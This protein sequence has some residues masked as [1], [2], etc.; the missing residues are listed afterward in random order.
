MDAVLKPFVPKAR[1][2]PKHKKTE[3][4]LQ[5][6]V[7]RYICKEYPDKGIVYSDYAAGVNLTDHQRRE[8]MAQRSEDGMPDIYIDYPSRG[9]HG[10]RI[11][12]KAEGTHIYK[13]DGKTLRKTPYTRRYIRNGKL[14]IK[15]GDHL[16]EQ[17]AV[18]QKYNQLGY[19]GRFAIGYDAATQLID[20]YFERPKNA[21]IF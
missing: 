4:N 15:R 3:Q 20:W 9:F 16:A 7:I 5:C 1:Y 11:E 18:L 12:L 13:K 17:A 10:L 8:M 6:R 21:Q 19:F 2:V 14:F